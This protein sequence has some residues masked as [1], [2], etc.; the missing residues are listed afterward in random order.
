MK[1]YPTLALMALALVFAA[2]SAFAVRMRV[3]DAPPIPGS[4]A[5]TVSDCTSNAVNTPC[6]ITD[7]SDT[8]LINFVAATNTGCQTAA[9]V[10]GVGTSGIAGFDFCMMLSNETSPQTPLG[11][12]NFTFVVPTAD[13]GDDYSFV[14][15]DGIPGSVTSTVCPSGPLQAGDMVTAS[16]SVSPGLPV[17]E[18][19]YLFVDFSNNPGTGS[20]TVDASV[21]EPGEL[22]LFGLGLLAIGVGYGWQKRRRGDSAHG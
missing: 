14:F 1:R 18:V 21:P 4:S 11:G 5:A 9:N 22:G 3:V 15:C 12:F 19:A 13:A 2:P 17:G 10:P 20:L 6:A 16:F 8:Y 7:V